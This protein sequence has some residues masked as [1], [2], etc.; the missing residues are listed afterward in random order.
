MEDMKNPFISSWFIQYIAITM[1][2]MK[3]DF[4]YCAERQDEVYRMIIQDESRLTIL[5]WKGHSLASLEV[6][7]TQTQ[8]IFILVILA[9]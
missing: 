7:S 8:K 9:F 2:V 6:C 1:P 5:A 4:L 3:E